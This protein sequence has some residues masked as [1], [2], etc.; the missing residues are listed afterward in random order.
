MAY[1][2]AVLAGLAFG[3]GDQ[4]LGTLTAGAVLGTWTWTVS[5]MSAPWL[6]VP[7]VAGLTQ[8]SERRAMALGLVV[9]LSAL[10][11]YF[12]MAHSP[13]EGGPVEDW[14]ARVVR[15]IT[16]GYNP[17]WIAGGLVTGPLFGLLG[18]RWRTKRSWVSAAAVTVALC[19]EPLA[20]GISGLLSGPSS[21]WVAEMAVGFVAAGLFA[22]AIVTANRKGRP[23]SA[24]PR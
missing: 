9:T 17:L 20:R 11:G 7:F 23:A 6:L 19:L 24:A 14:P 16:T 5:G 4:Y 15:M 12:V 18:Q 10:L 2:V 21:V 22:W 1:A 13:V 8:E 3:A